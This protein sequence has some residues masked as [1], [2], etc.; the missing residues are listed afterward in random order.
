MGCTK[1]PTAET[2]VALRLPMLEAYFRHLP[3]YQVLE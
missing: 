2:A 3:L 1:S